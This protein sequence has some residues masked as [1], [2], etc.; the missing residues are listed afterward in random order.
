MNLLVAGDS[1][2]HGHNLKDRHLNSW[3][4]V[5]TKRLGYQLIDTSKPGVGNDLIINSVIGE[6]QAQKI[7]SVIIGFTDI[8]RY[9]LA[10]G[11]DVI[12]LVPN[13]RIVQN[14]IVEE[15]DKLY[16]K[17][18]YNELYLL[19]K[20]INQ[21]VMLEGYLKSKKIKYYFFNAFGNR[22]ILL[23]N[24][25]KVNI[26]SINPDT[27]IGWPYDDMNTLTENF[28]RLPCGHPGVEAHKFWADMLYDFWN[29]RASFLFKF[30][31][32]TG[33]QYQ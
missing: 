26:K 17:N 25:N 6:T 21:V 24:Y 27:F 20:F 2:T 10:Q 9:E 18:F 1:F 22:K 13:R 11:D 14:P 12:Q 29:N 4:N 23:E 19:R 8:A 7:D 3:P 15:Y 30:K 16:T 31:K 33:R 32:L 5:L 28:E